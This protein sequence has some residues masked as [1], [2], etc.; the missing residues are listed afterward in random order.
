MR[1]VETNMRSAFLKK[2]V[3][4]PTEVLFARTA[5]QPTGALIKKQHLGRGTISGDQFMYLAPRARLVSEV[6]PSPA[7]E[8]L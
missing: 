6:V 2:C 5:R 1:V 7:T 3:Y 4:S 8:V